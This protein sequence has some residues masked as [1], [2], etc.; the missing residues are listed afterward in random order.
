MTRHPFAV[1]LFT[2]AVLCGTLLRLAGMS[3][4][5]WFDEIKSILLVQSTHSLWQAIW[6]I[7]TDNKHHLIWLWMWVVGP[8]KPAWLYRAPSLLAGVA[9]LPVLFRLVWRD[10]GVL[11]A[12]LAVLF[13]AFCCPLIFY[14]SEARGYSLVTLLAVWA[15]SLAPTASRSSIG[16]AI[17]FSAAVVLGFLAHL[18]FAYIYAGLLVWTLLEAICQPRC[19]LLLYHLPALIILSMISLFD[20]SKMRY[21]GGPPTTGIQVLRWSLGWTFAVPGDGIVPWLAGA[22][23]LVFSIVGLTVVIRKPRSGTA[24]FGRAAFFATA[25]VIAPVLLTLT[26]RNPFLAT[27]Y[28]LVCIPMIAILMSVGL[29]RLFRW[30]LVKLA[31]GVLLALMIIASV[32]NTRQLQLLGRGHV[33]ECL[34]RM[35]AASTA[36]SI[37]VASERPLMDSD[38]LAYY[39]HDLPD[40]RQVVG[41]VEHPQWWILDLDTPLAKGPPTIVR[42]GRVYTLDSVYPSDPVSGLTWDLY[43]IQPVDTSNAAG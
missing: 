31:T 25:L 27:R 14:C 3:G 30:T 38:C 29:A 2:I 43:R 13:C 34:A 20:V 6:S 18:T 11:P 26:R 35:C 39:A 12:G 16:R 36:G 22:V 33:R 28:Y 8:H 4:E 23:A 5:L 24:D 1:L 41:G 17:L 9:L 10:F 32:S 42:R 21:G 19:I 7:H 40:H 37:T 15:Y